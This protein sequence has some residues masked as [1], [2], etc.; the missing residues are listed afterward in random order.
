M[1][2]EEG[3]GGHL[4]EKSIVHCSNAS[5]CAF[6]PMV[7]LLQMFNASTELD[8]FLLTLPPLYDV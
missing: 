7:I 8:V 5:E 4:W 3:G 1:Q 6:L 2:G